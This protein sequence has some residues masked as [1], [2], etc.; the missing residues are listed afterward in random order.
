M[1]RFVTLGA[2]I[3]TVFAVI[4]CD[5][6][7]TASTPAVSA[8]GSTRP[9]PSP[10]QPGPTVAVT[11]TPM[12]SSVRPATSWIATTPM[13]VAREEHTATRLLD[14]RVLVVG[15]EAEGSYLDSV[16][17]F[18]PTTESWTDAAPLSIGRSDH[19]ALLLADGRVLVAGGQSPAA[20]TG[21][22]TRRAE[23]FDPA[24]GAWSR[25]G[26]SIGSIYGAGSGVALPDG[27]AVFHATIESGPY[28]VTSILQRFD[29]DDGTWTRVARLA[30]DRI[31]PSMAV[32]ADGR[33]L[34]AGGSS[35]RT[36]LPS[37]MA[38]A[39]IFDPATDTLRALAD[40]PEPG[41]GEPAALLPDGRVFV[42]GIER[43]NVFD[44][45]SAS[46]TR[47]SQAAHYRD[48]QVAA[49]LPDGRIVLGGDSSCHA[50]DRT[51]EIYDPS[52]DTWIDV[53]EIY[54]NLGLTMT[55]LTDGRVL[56]AG[57]GLPCDDNQDGNFGPFAT[58]FLL[59]PAAR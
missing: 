8:P 7:P 32:M 5:A 48:G 58:A 2:T 41:F 23:I 20:G 30:A 39:W 55:T 37:P 29:P 21:E 24:T 22:V 40:M 3:V 53:G 19:T 47:T 35:D 4:A 6:S 46:W 12:P 10:S 31:R 57:G 42:T 33:I 26:T 1:N 15:G 13:K 43:S 49:L 59:E 44:P 18:D 14:G 27:S 16:E 45:A 34:I 51:S 50:D 28:D 56:L 11:A 36:E 9:A 17:I 25:A 38:D 54:P 52:S